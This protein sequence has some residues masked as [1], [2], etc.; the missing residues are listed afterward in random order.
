MVPVLGIRMTYLEL[1]A[2]M[3]ELPQPFLMAQFKAKYGVRAHSYGVGALLARSLLL[4]RELL[5]N[6]PRRAA[7]HQY[8]YWVAP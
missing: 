3:T 1:L 7:S 8:E 4:R 5:R 6:D 2:M